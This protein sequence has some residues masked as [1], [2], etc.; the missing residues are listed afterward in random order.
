MTEAQS[1][2]PHIVIVSS[3]ISADSQ[4]I[5]L[6]HDYF[7][8]V[9]VVEDLKRVCHLLIEPKSKLFIFLGDT[10]SFCLAS[11]YKCISI[12]Q[13]VPCCE[14]KM[15][16][17]IAKNS[18]NEAFQAYQDHVIDNYLVCRPVYERVRIV[19]IVENQLQNLKLRN[20]AHYNVADFKQAASHY[21]DELIQLIEDGIQHKKEIHD[22]TLDASE[23]TCKQL[24]K[25]L[26]HI[27]Q[28]ELPHINYE[29]LL[30]TLLTRSNKIPLE[31]SET[32]KQRTVELL[33]R[34]LDHLET[35]Q[36]LMKPLD[37]VKIESLSSQK[38][39]YQKRKKQLSTQDNRAKI[40]IIEDDMISLQLSKTLLAKAGVK[41]YSA[42]NG[43]FAL[44]AINTEK[45]DLILMDINLPDTSGIDL[46]KQALSR[47]ALNEETPI[48]ML[49]GNKTKAMVDDAIA[50]GAKAYLVKPLKDTT[51]RKLFRRFRVPS[52]L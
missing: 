24:D 35:S 4:F 14:H 11:Y 50:H 32:V 52:T 47:G 6:V 29:N 2:S 45:Y 28:R 8:R 21:P 49:T 38:S 46:L 42:S 41:A 37:I 1:N 30:S 48:V 40:L 12:T 20:F 34:C 19:Q 17:G 39:E 27:N 43:E 18:E 31:R 7:K 26:L 9:E 16:A 13:K 25:A 33:H 3:D 51:V 23:L 10:L 5:E 44:Q 22:K 15:L 36:I